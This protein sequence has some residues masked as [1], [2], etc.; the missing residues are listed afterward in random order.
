MSKVCVA[1]KFEQNMH[2]DIRFCSLVVTLTLFVE[3]TVLWILVHSYF[4]VVV[5]R[6]NVK[7]CIGNSDYWCYGSQL[8]LKSESATVRQSYEKAL[9]LQIE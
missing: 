3:M 1:W 7:Y 8:N 2:K 4:G 5:E 9:L 6:E